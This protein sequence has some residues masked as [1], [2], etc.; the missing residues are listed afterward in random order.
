MAGIFVISSQNNFTTKKPVKLSHNNLQA[1][2][3]TAVNEKGRPTIADHQTCELIFL[4][5]HDF[6]LRKTFQYSGSTFRI[7][8][9]YILQDSIIHL[10]NLTGSHKVGEASIHDGHQLH[11]KWYHHNSLYGKG[12]EMFQ[13]KSNFTEKSHSRNFPARMLSFLNID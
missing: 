5:G 2:T 11:I 9:K 7:P 4:E 12:I 3:W 6:E 8:G 1:H 10:K 13:P